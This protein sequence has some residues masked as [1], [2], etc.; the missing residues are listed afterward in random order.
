MT[1]TRYHY[2]L[3][4]FVDCLQFRDF[5]L[6]TY[7]T[8]YN[9]VP[10]SPIYEGPNDGVLKVPVREIYTDVQ[11][12]QYDIRGKEKNTELKSYKDMFCHQNKKNKNIFLKGE[13][14]A[15]K[16]TWCLNL[17]NAWCE[18][19]NKNEGQS[20]QQFESSEST[21]NK[22]LTEA[23][24]PFRYL[25]F[26]Q[27]RF[28]ESKST[29]KD[30]ICSQIFERCTNYK[31]IVEHILQ[32]YS[33]TVLILLDGYDEYRGSLSFR[34][35]N[36]STVIITTR[37]WKLVTFSSDTSNPK[38]DLELTL[39]GLN[40]T[41]VVVMIDKAMK[42]FEDEEDDVAESEN[43]RIQC[44][45]DIWSVG[46]SESVKIPLILLIVILTWLKNNFTLS[47]SL[48][49]NLLGML[50]VIF[51]RGEEKVSEH[52]LAMLKVRNSKSVIAENI[53]S[54][55][56]DN[57]ILSRY[58]NLLLE[59]G[60][61]SFHGLSD[62]DKP[63]ALVFT[64]KEVMQFV[65]PENL[66]ICFKFGLLSAATVFHTLLEKKRMCI[67]FYHK[68]IQEFFAALWIV[69]NEKALRA[70][71]TRLSRKKD[72][73]EYDKVML[74][75]SGLDPSVGSLLTRELDTSSK[76]CHSEISDSE[77]FSEM[78]LKCM[79]EMSTCGE[80]EQP[81]FISEIVLQCYNVTVVENLIKL[82]RYNKEYLLTLRVSMNDEI[83]T[84]YVSFLAKDLQNTT[85]LKSLHIRCGAITGNLWF[86]SLPAQPQKRIEDS[87]IM[88]DCV[89]INSCSRLEEIYLE[90]VH[91][92]SIKI[93]QLPQLNTLSLAK[94]EATESIDLETLPSLKELSM[95]EVNC[96]YFRIQAFPNL[97]RLNQWHNEIHEAVG[98]ENLSVNGKSSS[99]EIT[100]CK[101]ICVNSVSS[102]NKFDLLHKHRAKFPNQIKLLGIE[103]LTLSTIDC[104][105]LIFRTFPYLTV[106][107]LEHVSN[108]DVTTLVKKCQ[109]LKVLILYDIT[110]SSC[111]LAENASI[112]KLFARHLKL[113][114][115]ELESMPNL[116]QLEL[117]N[118][119]VVEYMRI[120]NCPGLTRNEEIAIANVTCK[121]I[122]VQSITILKTMGMLKNSDTDSVPK[123]THLWLQS[124]TLLTASGDDIRFER[125]P[126]LTELQI[127]ITGDISSN[128]S[129][130]ELLETCPKLKSLALSG[131]S[132]ESCCLEERLALE[133]FSAR[134]LEVRDL[135]LVIIINL[136]QLHLKNIQAAESILIEYCPNLCELR[137]ISIE[138]VKCKQLKLNALHRLKHLSLLQIN[139]TDLA[140]GNCSSL[141]MITLS[142]IWAK[143][144]TFG[145]LEHLTELTLENVC[146]INLNGVVDNCIALRILNL[147]DVTVE[148]F[149]L[150][151]MHSLEML[152]ALRLKVKALELVSMQNL[153]YIQL[154][155]IKAAESIQ[156][157]CCPKLIN[158]NKSIKNVECKHI[159]VC[160]VHS[161]KYIKL[162][163]IKATDTI[164]LEN[165]SSV[166]QIILS[167][168]AAKGVT[169]GLFENLT[170]LHLDHASHIH[171]NGFIKNLPRLKVLSLFDVTS[172]NICIEE[173]RS[174][175]IVSA[176]HL[177]LISLKLLEIPNLMKLELKDVEAAE[178]IEI[179]ICKRYIEYDNILVE[180]LDCKQFKL[181]SL[182]KLK[183]LKLF[184]INTTYH[185]ELGNCFSLEPL[186]L[187]DITAKDIM[188]GSLEHLA[189]LT[190]ENVG[191]INW[192][193]LVKNCLSLKSLNLMGVTVE[194]ISLERDHSPKYLE[195]FQ[196]NVTDTMEVDNC[197]S[198]EQMVF[199]DKTTKGVTIGLFEN[200]T[201]L[202][203]IHAHHIDLNGLAENCRRLKALSLF[204]VTS[205][206]ICI[207][208]CN[209]LEMLS[210]KCLNLISL[211]L[212]QIPNLTELELK[213]VIA[214]KS[215]EIGNCQN[216]IEHHNISIVNLKCKHLYIQSLPCAKGLS[217][218]HIDVTGLMRL[219]NWFCL[220]QLALF[221]IQWNN[222]NLGTFPSLNIVRLQQT[223]NINLTSLIECCPRIK[224]LSLVAVTSETLDLENCS[225]LK[226]FSALRLKLIDF[227]L[228]S[229]VSLTE[230][231][232]KDIDVDESFHIE[233][234]PN[235][236]R[237][238][239][240]SIVNVKCKQLKVQSLLNS[241]ITSL[242]SVRVDIPAPDNTQ[243]RQ[244]SK[245]ENET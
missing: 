65:H 7:E 193:G 199:S 100:K 142:N 145:S 53:S 196:I 86:L 34:G 116:T 195:M 239:D 163:Q 47:K 221:N 39:N 183:Q 175:E 177:K 46:L 205:E 48:T 60:Q 204:D 172:E 56:L 212:L 154:N 4:L 244:L 237:L 208:E 227:K 157:E 222:I 27:L 144:V 103:H 220:E 93:Y 94:I 119:K 162:F 105:N 16:S 245:P 211:K 121:S 169:I 129:V 217:L 61:L 22:D 79:T 156:V 97:T 35:L 80:S 89:S 50:E 127:E 143:D 148:N 14:G 31:A 114:V 170:D 215:I 235:L 223:S 45:R 146:H 68:L 226:K 98:L 115:L 28:V 74:F 108:I 179:G 238:D 5:L 71:K 200:L 19:Q 63:N 18:A 44:L 91:C 140:I 219:D 138:T 187:S 216:L 72:I 77:R 54:C 67:S 117:R 88:S 198:A 82:I 230:I 92:K 118:I 232:L 75:I 224:E 228:L 90:K 209:S 110:A 102:L 184:H 225:S 29:I 164:E 83:P 107:R 15:G 243:D 151:R 166:G 32:N 128:I 159:K 213:D 11:I 52:V 85:F 189:K 185:R 171:L 38:I 109:V 99:A 78:I 62:V 3:V 194:N 158:C 57:P 150:E 12:L 106:L 153:T 111:R 24:T 181:H 70:A 41:G 214:T 240:I 149:S 55:I 96:L 229:L 2:S 49:G 207:E 36:E 13:A 76:K 66:D 218:W 242:M 182:Y 180:T 203:L 136:T 69:S 33:E 51:S 210:A 236:S 131:I 125:F 178:S 20:F 135:K 167:H 141:E 124:L 134:N 126:N 84:A 95:Q 1:H 231:R 21:C 8:Y 73:L 202:R 123:R 188:F 139:A 161:I 173:S 64:Q 112:E 40:H 9:E 160:A 10:L 155:D 37:P 234:C 176:R 17:I 104:T 233:D 87:K 191:H 165:C 241:E 133:R 201:D 26:G 6:N 43:K 137:D 190:L 192:N 197:S 174:L 132:S 186:K 101:K 58:Q 206:N 113:R 81:L 30:C 23:V 25:L 147:V 168:I 59:L 42:I 130:N 120:E 122:R 152:T